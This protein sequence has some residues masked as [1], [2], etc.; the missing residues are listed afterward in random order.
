MRKKHYIYMIILDKYLTCDSTTVS[1][2]Q[3][4]V[5]YNS[6]NL[7]MVLLLKKKKKHNTYL[8]LKT[9]C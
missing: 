2:L 5:E 9:S 3:R 4:F 1:R 6:T 7:A 8:L